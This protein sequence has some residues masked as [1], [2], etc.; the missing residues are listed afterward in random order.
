MG[1]LP[2]ILADARRIALDIAGF[3]M[4]FIERRREQQRQFIITQDEVVVDCRHGARG[5][6]RVRRAGDHAPGLSDGVDAAFAARY[7]PERRSIV[8]IAAAIPA[9]IPTVSLKGL[10]QRRR[11]L[12]PGCG[13]I[14]LTALLGERNEISNGGVKKPTQPYAFALAA[15]ADPVHSV[16]PV[17]STDQRQTVRSERKTTIETARAVF[18]KSGSL[19]RGHGLKKRILLIGRESH[20]LEKR[21]LLVEDSHITRHRY[22]L[23]GGVRQPEQVVRN[24]R[25]NALARGRQ[26]PVL[27]VAL[28]KLPCG[29]AQQMIARQ[30][31]LRQAERHPILQLIA[32]AIGAAGLVKARARP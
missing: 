4:G 10:A 23:C 13:A 9:A 31:R 12:P 15:G 16:V 11:V 21:D 6:Y 32:E 25:T 17:A 24:A 8:K 30:L 3:Q 14:V 22:I 7:R 5:A 19:V 28:G 18:E 20:A 2:A 26:P 27:N 29:C 1:I